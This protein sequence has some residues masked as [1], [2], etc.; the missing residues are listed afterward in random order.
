MRPWPSNDLARRNGLGHI[1]PSRM[2]SSFAT[3]DMK[4]VADEFC[5]TY[6]ISRHHLSEFAAGGKAACVVPESLAHGWDPHAGAL[7]TTTGDPQEAFYEA[8]LTSVNDGRWHLLETSIGEDARIAPTATVHD[9]VQIGAG[10]VIGD[11]AVI[12]PN[13]HLGDGVAIKPNAVIGGAGFEVKTLRGARTM[14][15]HM[16]GAWLDDHVAIGSQTCVDNGMFGEFTHIGAE[17]KIDNLV[18]VGHSAQLGPRGIVAA[19]SEIGAIFAEEG[20]WIGPRCATNQGVRLGRYSYLGT[21]SVVVRDV[22][23]HALAYGV[24]ARL[25]G[26]MCECRARLDLDEAAECACVRCGRSYTR[27]GLLVRRIEAAA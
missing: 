1:G 5:V 16:G 14:I 9:H 27:E 12:L 13:S 22:P 20:F 3:L 10:C 17:T 23:D 2:L 26:W 6:A 21:G 24:P 4:T 25:A 15:P 8:F 11:G 7:L 19:C 18:H